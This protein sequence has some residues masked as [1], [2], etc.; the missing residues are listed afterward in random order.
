MDEAVVGYGCVWVV[1]FMYGE[2]IDCFRCGVY[3]AGWTW[4]DK[5][6]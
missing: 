5:W 1:G 6:L 4:H 2:E 3:V